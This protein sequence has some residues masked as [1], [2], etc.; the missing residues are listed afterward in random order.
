M[1]AKGLVGMKVFTACILALLV[2]LGVWQLK[3]LEWKEGLIAR[4]E[5]RSKAPP[6]TLPQ[7]LEAARKDRDVNY[8]RVAVEGRFLNDK[9]RY[10]YALSDETAGWDVITPLATADGD[11]VLIDRGFVPDALRDPASRPLGQTGEGVMVTGLL[12]APDTQAQFV[13]DNDPA[14][15]RWFWRDLAGMTASMFP[16]GSTRVAP[17]FLD[18]ERSEVPGDWPRGGQ[19]RLALPNNHLQYAMTWFVLAFCIAVIYVFYVRS[20]RREG[21]G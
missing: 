10:L 2:G 3:R 21:R 20:R 7:A 4:I 13:P 12:R 9:E 8:L 15:N 11:V 16:G 18:A 19:T 1:G 17:F 14:R 6:I 5:A